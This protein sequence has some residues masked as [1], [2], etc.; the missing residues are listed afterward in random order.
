[1]LSHPRMNIKVELLRE[2]SKNNAERIAALVCRQPQYFTELF[3]C[4]QSDNYRLSQRAAWPLGKIGEQRPELFLPYSEAILQLLEKPPHPAVARNL[5]RILQ[6]LSLPEA[7]QST[8]FD[9]AIRDLQDP[10]SPIA[11][12]VFAMSVAS[13]IAMPYSELRTELI[14]IIE[15]QLP[16]ASKAYLSRSRRLLPKLRVGR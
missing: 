11:I 10:S 9:L 7:S 13:K 15:G 2:H 14:L 4:L 12:K 1:M 6:D 16:Q 8:L 5:Y 3:L